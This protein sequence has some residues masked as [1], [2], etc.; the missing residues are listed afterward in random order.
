MS[1]VDGGTSSLG[2]LRVALVGPGKV[3]SSL[4]R[5]LLARG[6]VLQGVARGSGAAPPRWARTAGARVARLD[7][8]AT[9][10]G[11]LLLIAV[12][13]G[14]VQGVAAALAAQKLAPVAL[15][16]SGLLT[17]EALA[18]L[19]G[20]GTAVGGLHPLR[21]FPRPRPSPALASRTFF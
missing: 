16:T 17:A 3:G 10:D 7:E 21:A 20:A 15:H 8:L 18:P 11:D 6:A 12:P 14:A 9:S 5:W 1:A 19:R 4:A 13:D 2:G